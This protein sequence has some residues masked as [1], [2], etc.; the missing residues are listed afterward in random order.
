M[1]LE[2]VNL[3]IGL[4][5]LFSSF[6]S[7][8]RHSRC[9]YGLID[10]DMKSKNNTPPETPVINNNESTALLHSTEPTQPIT[11]PEKPK[12]KNWL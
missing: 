4:I 10:I 6:I 11:I 1:D 12:I 7:H 5:A 9:C 2:Y 3:M 8:L